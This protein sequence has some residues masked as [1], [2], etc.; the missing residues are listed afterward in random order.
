MAWKKQP[1]NN[2]IRK[3]DV[4]AE[5]AIRQVLQAERKAE[6]AIQ[7]CEQE[8][9]QIINDARSRAQRV[10]TRTDQRITNMEMRYGH[11]LD[12]DIKAIE[13]EGA[14]ELRLDAGQQYDA[15]A[16]QTAIESLAIELCLD[17]AVEND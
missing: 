17:D 12:R 10:N 8:A 15:D 11:K 9:L 6:Q 4:Q 2:N 3:P 5:E 16:L 13:R 14:A 7:D 1:M